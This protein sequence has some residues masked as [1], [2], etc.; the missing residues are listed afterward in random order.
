MTTQSKWVKVQPT[1]KETTYINI[2]TVS[3]LT[4]FFGATTATL[5]FAGT[6]RTLVIPTD[7]AAQLV[8]LL[9]FA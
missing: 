1:P 4:V 2:E 7:Q 8:N 9:S 3:Q 6:D 5:N